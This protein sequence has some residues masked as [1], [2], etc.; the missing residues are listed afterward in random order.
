M[1]SYFYEEMYLICFCVIEQFE[2]KDI[3]ERLMAKMI[4]QISCTLLKNMLKFKTKYFKWCCTKVG[5]I[6]DYKMKLCINLK[7]GK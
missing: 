4:F 7:N 6:K 2:E 3:L 1:L 5:I